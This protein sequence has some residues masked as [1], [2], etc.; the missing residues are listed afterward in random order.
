MASARHVLEKLRPSDGR[1]R[2]KTLSGVSVLVAVIAL[3]V[4][5]LPA[6]A[7]GD[8]TTT[9]DV[10]PV[11]VTYGGGSGACSATIE[12]RLPSAAGNELHVNNPVPGTHQLEGPDGTKFTITVRDIAA[13]RVFDFTVLTEGIVV[14]DVIVNGGPNNNHYDYDGGPGTVRDD[15]KLHAPRKNARSLHNLSHINICYD[16]PGV[17]LFVCDAEPPVRLESEGLFTIAEATIFTNSAV[18]NCADKRGSFFIDNTDTEETDPSVTLAFTGDTGQVVAGRLDVTKDFGDPDFDPLQ[19]RRTESDP[20]V[21]VEWCNIRNRTAEDGPQ[22][23][24]VLASDDY[25]SLVGV[26]D[27]DGAAISCKVVEEE[28]ATGIQYTVVYFELEDPQWR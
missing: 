19:Y 4:G 17:T 27:D 25:P 13:G 2:I 20:Y 10:H 15:V 12:G 22:F 26:T 3:L 5:V 28:N 23:E 11:V 1:I 8:G 24:D 16:V 14:Y 18:P 21:D 9:H 7:H 6:I